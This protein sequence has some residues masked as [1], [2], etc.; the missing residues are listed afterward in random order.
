MDT[1]GLAGG[2]RQQAI[3]P[4]ENL[5]QVFIQFGLAGV[6]GFLIG[7]ERE[8]RAKGGTT[9]GIRDFVLFSLIGAI[10]AFAGAQYDNSWFVIAGFAGF[11]ALLVSSYWAD[12]TH[13]AGISTELA[14]IFTFFLG[15]LII[16]QAYDLA[17]ALAIVALAVLFPKQAI[18]QF[19][20]KIQVR[21]LQAILL[22]LTITF[23][24]LPV[25][26]RQ[27]LDTYLT[28]PV[29]HVESVSAAEERI[30]IRPLNDQ[31]L[32]T[33]EQL[34]IF[35]SG[36]HYLG[37]VTLTAIDR[38]VVT[39]DYKGEVLPG[40]TQ[41]LEARRKLGIPFINIM[42]SA[43]EPYKVWL[44]VVLVSFISFVGYILIKAVGP[45]SGIGLTGLIGGLVSSTVTTLSFARRSRENPAG[46]RHFT[47]AIVLAASI[48][49]PRLILEIA[50]VNQE[51]VKNIALPLVVMG[52]T[53]LA[54]AGYHLL[55][56]RKPD[57]EQVQLSLENPFSLSSAVSFALIFASILMITRLATHYLG[58]AWLPLVAIVSGLTDADAIAFSLSN[59]QKAELITTDWASFNLVLGAISNTFMKLFLV[60][61]LGHPALF[62]NLLVSFLIVGAVGLLTTF[63]YYDVDSMF[64]WR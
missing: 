62:R 14:A 46:N 54:L 33:G 50:V 21:E 1:S 16:K 4:R 12:R 39:G 8:M 38:D 25:L 57:T 31:S 9:L 61:G 36:W 32:Q 48:M 13:G 60:L 2:A 53:G 29:G 43:I 7:L 58:N 49:F 10:S 23:I 26:P 20:A 3:M 6:L 56:S 45:R 22:F 24:V 42:L 5:L 55:K 34:E 44:I 15:V 30:V 47:V 52:L 11:L 63:L 37:T 51:M 35:T 40:S 17:I 59:L 19:R 28:F 41:G 64:V 18:K 27:S